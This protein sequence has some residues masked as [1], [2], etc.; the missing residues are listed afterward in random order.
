MLTRTVNSVAVSTHDL[1]MQPVVLSKQSKMK[2]VAPLFYF[3]C[4]KTI[5]PKYFVVHGKELVAPHLRGYR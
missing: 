2:A 3:L 5:V 4:A 1:S